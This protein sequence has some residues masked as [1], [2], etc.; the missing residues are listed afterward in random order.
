MSKVKIVT[1][2]PGS[3]PKANAYADI[4]GHGRI[5]YGKTAPAPIGKDGK[6]QQLR[7]MGKARTSKN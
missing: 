5:P 3:A 6:T 2:T 7:G 4:Q 1:N